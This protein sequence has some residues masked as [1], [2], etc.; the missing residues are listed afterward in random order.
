MIEVSLRI[1]APPV[2]RDEVL[3]VLQSLKGPTEAAIACRG[4]RILQ[5]T[6]DID[7]LTYLVRWDTQQDLEDHIRSDRFRRLLP[8]IEM[9]IQPPE[10][11]VNAI[12]HVG[13]IE[14]LVALLGSK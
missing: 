14:F 1:V 13:G 3:D 8:Y 2:K 5:D 10:V 11:Q 6:E 7:A 12:D 4:C 9:S